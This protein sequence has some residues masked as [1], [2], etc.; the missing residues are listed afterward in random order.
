MDTLAMDTAVNT[1]YVS[2]WY[3]CSQR[4]PMR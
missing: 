2:S 1:T 3:S 4:M